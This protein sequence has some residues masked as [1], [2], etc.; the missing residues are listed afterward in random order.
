[1]PDEHLELI[2]HG[3]VAREKVGPGNVSA[4]LDLSA[5]AEDDFPA[6]PQERKAGEIDLPHDP[7][8]SFQ[9]GEGHP[10][11]EEKEQMNR[12]DQVEEREG[13]VQR[14]HATLVPFAERPSTEAG[15][16]FAARQLS[17]AEGPPDPVVIP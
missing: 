8:V 10:L 1:M 7:G 3:C 6:G 17:P 4:P 9:E 2:R 16:Q 13:V 15:Q 5:Q 12:E 14:H 11:E